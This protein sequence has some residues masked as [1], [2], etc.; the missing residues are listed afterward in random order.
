MNNF[1]ESIDRFR[2]Q[3]RSKTDEQRKQSLLIYAAGAIGLFLLVA[4]ISGSAYAGLQPNPE[5]GNI[6]YG[7]TK[8]LFMTVVVYLIF[9]GL[10][11]MITTRVTYA[12]KVDRIDERGVRVMQ[13]DDYGGSRY[14]NDDEMRKVF[15]VGD[16]SRID[17]EVYAQ[18]TF[19]GG[20]KDVIAYKKPEHGASGNRNVLTLASS[21]L[22]KSFTVVRNNILQAVRRG[23]S[24]VAT[25][26][27]GELYRTLGKYLVENMNADVH[28]L[29]LSEPEYSDFWDVLEET[30]DPETERLDATRL[31]DFANIYMKNSSDDQKEDFWYGC[32]VNL[33]QAAIGFVAYKHENEIITRFSSLY[34]AITGRYSDDVTEHMEHSACGFPWCRE[35]ILEAAREK[36]LDE[37]EIRKTLYEIQYVAPSTPFTIGEVY[38]VLLTF[39]S[40]S[41]EMGTIPEW[42]PAHDAYLMYMTNDTDT[43]R[44][45]ALQGAQMR[46]RLFK[47]T[48]IRDMLSHPG[49]HIDDATKKLSVY[50]V[51]ISNKTTTTKPI[52][53]LFFSF[54]FKDLM[55]SWDKAVAKYGEEKNP[56]LGITVMLD[57]F[58]SVGVIGG[59]PG[60]F[61]VVMSNA[62][63]Y[64][65]RIW[66]ILQAYSQLAALYGPEVGNVIQGNC[67]TILFLGCNDLDTAKFIS[68]FAAG[69]ATILSESHSQSQGGIAADGPSN[70]S[71]T[72]RA[73]ITVEEA[74]RWKNRVLIVKQGEYIAKAYPFPWIE[75][76]AY[77]L[78]KDISIYDKIKP[79][80]ERLD[81]IEASRSAYGDMDSYINN[82]IRK[83]S[84]NAKAV[85]KDVEPVAIDQKSEE[86]RKDKTSDKPRSKKRPASNHTGSIG[87]DN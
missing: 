26:P 75:H 49:I 42:H 61:G 37:D 62:R 19:E 27:S 13:N 72:K 82:A 77:K 14:M 4:F 47:N 7:L 57:E 3:W 18:M 59:Q 10:I 22:G 39:N 65:I 5:H 40:Y 67:S 29:N 43:V 52:A 55:D 70:L 63:K 60:T 83:V 69:D 66:P 9:V 16:I 25:D 86:Q 35:R 79:I 85:I 64:H 54:L 24:V 46:F 81:E 74:R 2:A 36:G 44:K 41:E 30:L 31:D 1:Q 6:Y 80:Q 12:N 51:A 23:E 33:I 17:N 56:R 48:Q 68:E 21:G 38:N 11:F 73:F 53:S 28:L 84:H 32:A 58:Y 34:S 50:F 78:C 87:D 20:G 71:T 8:T 45:S 76:P 15:E